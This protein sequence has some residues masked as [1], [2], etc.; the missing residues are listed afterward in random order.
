MTTFEVRQTYVDA[1]RSLFVFAGKVISGLVRP[2]MSILLMMNEDVTMEVP[3]HGVESLESSGA[4]LVALTVELEDQSD[5]D[6]LL[7]F[8]VVGEVIVLSDVA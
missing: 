2:G 7:Q 3:V 5:A 4:E 8:D 1:S 6:F